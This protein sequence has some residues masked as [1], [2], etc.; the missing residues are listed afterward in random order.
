[1]NYINLIIFDYPYHFVLY[2]RF[3]MKRK[4]KSMKWKHNVMVIMIRFCKLSMILKKT[5]LKFNNFIKKSLLTLK[6]VS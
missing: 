3:E 5:R 2:S 6:R 1:M 4:A